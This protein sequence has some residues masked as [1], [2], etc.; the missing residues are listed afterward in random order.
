VV[1]Y[2]GGGVGLRLSFSDVVGLFEVSDFDL[3]LRRTRGS[4]VAAA[5]ELELAE[6]QAGS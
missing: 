4:S 5:L 2:V 1:W 3:D 6:S